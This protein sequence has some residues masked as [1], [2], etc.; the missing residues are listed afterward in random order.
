M[1]VIRLLRTGRR[2]QPSFKVV[3]TEKTNAP[4]A[5]TFVEEVG[6]YNPRTKQRVLHKERIQ[7]WISK[8][9]QPSP[10][11]YNMLV[12]EGVVQG[13]K[14]PVHNYATKEQK[15]TEEQV[16]TQPAPEVPKT[17][18]DEAKEEQKKEE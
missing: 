17:K 2:N 15:K 18:T 7:Y 1:L 3:V 12:S 4:S 10:T 16:A 9:A 5:R 11:V 14:I 13:K 6:T 8:G